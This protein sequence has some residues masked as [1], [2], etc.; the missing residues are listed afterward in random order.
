[1]DYL[2]SIENN[3]DPCQNVKMQKHKNL[4]FGTGSVWDGSFCIS[5]WYWDSEEKKL[6]ASPDC[7]P[8]CSIANQCGV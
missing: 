4:H 7:N 1:M 2:I 8:R 3:L 5:G 6:V